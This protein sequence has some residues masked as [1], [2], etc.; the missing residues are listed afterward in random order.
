MFIAVNQVK[1]IDASLAKGLAHVSVTLPDWRKTTL[2][3]KI[4]ILQ[5]TPPAYHPP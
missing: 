3:L 4:M 5:P 2:S 1:L